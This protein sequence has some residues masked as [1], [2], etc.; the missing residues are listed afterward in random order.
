MPCDVGQSESQHWTT[1]KLPILTLPKTSRQLKGFGSTI[2][3]RPHDFTR[4][5]GAL[6][7]AC[8]RGEG[9]RGGVGALVHQVRDR[10][11][12]CGGGVDISC[13]IL[14]NL[15]ARKWYVPARFARSLCP[16]TSA[17]PPI[18]NKSAI[19]YH[20]SMLENRFSH[21]EGNCGGGFCNEG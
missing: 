6:P 11:G 13:L 8:G 16:A 9:V 10:V 1:L 17:M 2:R 15:G 3:A 19:H 21:N 18:R 14:I 7:K 4:F 5:I 20:S 12:E